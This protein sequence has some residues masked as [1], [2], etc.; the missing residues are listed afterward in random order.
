MQTINICLGERHTILVHASS[1]CTCFTAIKELTSPINLLE[2][3]SAFCFHPM[4]SYLRFFLVFQQV[5]TLSVGLSHE[6]RITTSIDT[7]GRLEL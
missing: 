3:L 6:E 5:M 1:E 2:Q 4:H 7:L